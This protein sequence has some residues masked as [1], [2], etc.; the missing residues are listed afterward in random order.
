MK[1]KILFISVIILAFLLRVWQID[2]FPKTLYGD[3]QAFAWNAYNILK[4]GQD[5]YGNSYPLQF[6]SFDDYK[7]PIPIY[8]LVPFFKVLGMNIFSIRLPI[9]I[10]GTLTVF[11]TYFLSRLFFG[12]KVSLLITFL[13]AVSSW[14]VH[15]SRGFFESTLALFW[16][17]CGV[18]FL[19]KD[20]DKLSY[21]ILGMFF[22]GL[23]I[24]S[25]FTPRI[26]IPIFIVFLFRK[27][28]TKNF[29]I[30]TLFLLI[31][32]LPLIKL[33][34]FEGGFS[35]FAKL[36]Q[37]NN[38]V[39][40][41]NVRHERYATNLPQKWSVI[42][43]NK[44]IAGARLVKNNFLEHMSANFWYIYG[45]NSLRYFTGNMGMF[46]LLEFPFL[47]I[48]IYFLLKEKKETAIFCLGWI[49]LASIP[50]SLVGRPFAVRSLAML[51]APFLFV[52]YGL[53]KVNNFN[54]GKFK[55][56]FTIAVTFLFIL[57]IGSLL[58]RYYLEYPVYAATWWG[59]EN[60]AALD[61][62]AVRESQYDNIFISDFYTGAAL[63][64]AVYNQYDPVEYRYA[65]NHPVTLADGR[66]L[67]KLGKYYFGSL[68]INRERLSQNIIPPR[69]LYI[70]R[71]E[72]ADS[73]ETINA[74]DDGR[75]IFKIYK[76]K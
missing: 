74:P 45:D 65:I 60:R 21:T 29:I 39:I 31:I 68:D 52:G 5:E 38:K 76:T 13:M 62:A 7:A 70:G 51:P 22:F 23:S 59:W 46:Y 18:Y 25:Y 17:V 3:E 41:D 32:S 40:E 4:L 34:V 49:I 53:Y 71:P 37:T 20:K 26:L 48:G 16:F 43:H 66:S 12:R 30:G 15:L 72:E 69:S 10:A 75:V 47:L 64:F 33:T 73:S 57:S 56:I 42:F 36:T 61:Y 8:L 67:V 27:S 24:Y 2:K 11:V 55:G 28:F 19:I 58:I 35:R 50:A 63:A 6:R 54:W 14:H 44:V 1:F 9:V